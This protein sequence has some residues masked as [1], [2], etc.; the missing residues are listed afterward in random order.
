VPAVLVDSHAHLDCDAFDADR[1]LVLARAAA[2]GVEDVVVPAVGRD[3]WQPILA[4]AARA[5]APR[6]HAAVGLHPVSLP[7]RPPAEDDGDLG[8]LAGLVARGGVV[9]IGECGLDAVI[10]LTTAPFARQERVLRFQLALARRLELPVIL[11]ARGPL[12]YRRLAELLAE[13]PLPAAGGV[14]HSYGG[15]VALLSAFL[16]AGLHFG[17]AGPATYPDARKVRASIQAL[18]A[19]RL[20]AETDAP[21]QT[22]APHRPA[23]SEPAYVADVLVGIAAARG[24]SLEATAELTASN[25]RRLFRLG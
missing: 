3:S 7:G 1:E 18:P 11:H 2:R 6:C 20:L 22:P 19:E 23:R 4:L 14:L 12:A 10:D 5:G 9:A 25:A 24:A 17:F 15:G 16:Q 21:D 8:A 13:E